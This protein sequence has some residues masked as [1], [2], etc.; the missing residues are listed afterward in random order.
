LLLLGLS[1][2]PCE[3]KIATFALKITSRG[4][5]HSFQ[6]YAFFRTKKIVQG[7]SVDIFKR[8]SAV[9]EKANL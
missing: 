5:L 8:F 3:N 6:R 2:S 1:S 4:V 9:L 7:I